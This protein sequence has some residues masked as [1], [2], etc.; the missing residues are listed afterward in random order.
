[1][2]VGSHSALKVSQED[3]ELFGNITEEILTG[4]KYLVIRAIADTPAEKGRDAQK[5][6]IKEFYD[7]VDDVPLQ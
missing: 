5:R 2:V 7:T 1:V 4:R 6:I 3:P